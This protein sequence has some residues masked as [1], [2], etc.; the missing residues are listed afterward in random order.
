M[1][2]PST[3]FTRRPNY[4][5]RI[6]IW[7]AVIIAGLVLSGIT[8]FPLQTELRWLL[9]VLHASPLRDAAQSTGLLAWIE[10]V[11]EALCNTYPRY[12]F[13][14]YGTDWLAFAHL[15]IG[16]AFIGPFLD[17][18]RNKWIVTFGL[19]RLRR[20]R[21]ARPDRGSYSRHP[22]RLAAYRLQF[23]SLRQYP[24]SDLPASNPRARTLKCMSQP[25][26]NLNCGDGNSDSIG[27]QC[28]KAATVRKSSVPV[29][30]CSGESVRP[31]RAS[32]PSS[33]NS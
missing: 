28:F 30:L 13:L 33:R 26:A 29:K 16:V 4:L 12:P 8:A 17:P 24:A 7:L 25:A 1:I 31:G 5:R 27:P 15:V 6:R 10:R 3:I 21:P 20:R 2:A 19:T 18:V 11:N 32:A 22:H 23:W 14:A 9:F